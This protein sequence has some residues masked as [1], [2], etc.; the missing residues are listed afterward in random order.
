[1]LIVKKRNIKYKT[2]INFFLTLFLF[3]GV[4]FFLATPV[5]AAT[6]YLDPPEQT[7]GP[8]QTVKIKVKI[9]VGSDECINVAQIGIT[10]PSDILEFTDFDS[11]DSFLSMWVDKP[12]QSSVGKINSEGKIIFSGGIPGGYCGVIPGDTGESNVLGS[13]IFKPKKPIIFHKARLDFSPETQALL[14]DG[15]G[16][17]ATI[18]TQGTDL[19]IDENAKAAADVWAEQIA[20][21]KIP[22]EPFVI[23]INNSPRIAEG[24]YFIVFSTVDKQT[25]VDHYE[26][27]EAKAD[28]LQPKNKNLFENFIEKFIKAKAPLAPAW[29]KVSSPYILKDQSLKSVIRVKAVDRAGNERVVEFNNSALQ[30][31]K[32][33]NPTDWRFIIIIGSALILLL[34]LVPIIIILR[35]RM[36]R[37]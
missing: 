36:R 13:L 23:E 25:G 29:I 7:I 12:D 31:L 33:S 34:I 9:G 3:V 10:F 1:M 17:M 20:A 32:D 19:V 26:I 21:D 28:D 18:S 11:G 2:K 22:P 4:L 6:L 16:T 27:L 37:G 8:D 35:K 14:N 15:N 30:N 24:K 5:K